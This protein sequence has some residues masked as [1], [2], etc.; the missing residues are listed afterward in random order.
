[1][2]YVY[3]NNLVTNLCLEDDDEDDEDDDDKWHLLKRLEFPSL[4]LKPDS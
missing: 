4:T 3:L 1:M 2:R